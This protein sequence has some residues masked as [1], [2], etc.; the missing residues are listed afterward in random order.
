M[1]ARENQMKTKSEC[2]QTFAFRVTECLLDKIQHEGFKETK[3]LVFMFI[4]GFL[5][6]S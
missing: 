6:F 5:T 3:S 4:A 2:N 1:N